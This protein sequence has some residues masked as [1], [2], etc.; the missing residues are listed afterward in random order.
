[1]KLLGK[2]SI[3]FT[4]LLA[5]VLSGCNESHDDSS[6]HAGN[7]SKS[8]HNTSLT[9]IGPAVV[10]EGDGI[11]VEPSDE[12]QT[13]ETPTLPSKAISS[14]LYYKLKQSKSNDTYDTSNG[15]KAFSDEDSIKLSYSDNKTNNNL[16]NIG[17]LTIFSECTQLTYNNNESY[18]IDGAEAYIHYDVFFPSFLTENDGSDYTLF[19]D[20][21]ESINGQKVGHVGAGG[22]A[23]FKSY[24]NG[25]TWVYDNVSCVNINSGTIKYIPN[26]QDIARTTLYKI[27][28]G[29]KMKT[30]KVVGKKKVWDFWPF[31]SH[32]EDDYKDFYLTLIQESIFLLGS[33]HISAVFTSEE[34]QYHPSQDDGNATSAELLNTMSSLTDGSVTFNS[35][36]YS[37]YG[38]TGL[39]CKYEY[40]DEETRFA[41]TGQTFTNK[42]RYH[43]RVTNQIGTYRDFT[44]YIVDKDTIFS[45]Y[46]GDGIFS[47]TNRIFDITSPYPVYPNGTVLNINANDPYLP[48][49]SG[50]LLITKNGEFDQTPFKTL[51][52]DS[53]KETI[54]L[55]KDNTYCLDIYTG[56]IESSGQK[57]NYRFFFK[58]VN[59]PDYQPTVNHNNLFSS[60]RNSNLSLKAYATNFQTTLGG[61]YVFLFPATVAGYEKASNFAYD[62]EKRFI[63]TFN[64]NNATYYYYRGKRYD[65]K[66]ELY[67]AINEN[68][69]DAVY[70]SY[71]NPQESYGVDVISEDNLKNIETT[72]LDKDVRVCVDIQT[73]NELLAKDKLLNGFS[74]MQAANYESESV[75]IIDEENHSI[76]VPY[77]VSVDELLNK[78]G[79]YVVQEKNWNRTIEYT[80]N[81]IAKDDNTAIVNFKIYNGDAFT[82][83][84]VNKSNDSQTFMGNKVIFESSKDEYDSQTIAV[85]S[86]VGFRETCL[87]SELG[88][89]IYR[90]TDQGTYKVEIINRLGYSFDFNFVI[91]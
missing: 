35:F 7:S 24:D 82:K 33:N 84:S 36:T 9:D 30:R 8:E 70:L 21:E 71:I 20:K 11:S 80:A 77:G 19:I 52:S 61:S 2:I 75:K 78:T 10:G 51:D 88:G 17:A 50:N 31:K 15:A 87:V 28:T 3:I 57:I 63:Q 34:T 47:R 55:D 26:G 13:V 66:V 18:F 53:L 58:I 43:F 49:L 4:S 42:G 38:Q 81:Y 1:M 67:Q 37:D 62:M 5:L 44:I 90:L 41:S 83:Y 14:K 74:F 12:T 27:V 39:I 76:D 45:Q 46:F 69:S 48:P 29:Y 40:N 56:G 16:D 60:S 73:K 32:M 65:S 6:A 64:T 59:R 89:M 22:F 72:V 23:L 85:V 68:I 91:E 54:T 86:R 79:K 25:L